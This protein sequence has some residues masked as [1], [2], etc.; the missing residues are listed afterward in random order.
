MNR[1]AADP[2]ALVA[3]VDCAG[4]SQG[5]RRG[6]RIRVFELVPFLAGAKL[7]GNE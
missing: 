2:K 6:W 1:E 5:I 4:P 7:V 3:M